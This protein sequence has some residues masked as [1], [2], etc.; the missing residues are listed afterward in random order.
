MAESE[1]NLGNKASSSAF[2]RARVTRDSSSTAVIDERAEVAGKSDR[3]RRAGAVEGASIGGE[4]S[5]TEVIILDEA[6]AARETRGVVGN[7][8]NPRVIELSDKISKMELRREFKVDVASQERPGGE[9]A[10]HSR[11][12]ATGDEDGSAEILSRLPPGTILIKQGGAASAPTGSR[13]R[14]DSDYVHDSSKDSTNSSGSSSAASYT[15]A[16]KGRR[17]QHRTGRSKK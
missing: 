7:A 8:H 11:G 15:A 13:R 6:P 9:S 4:Q 5:R 10:N 2:S 3:R 14:D 1:D 16:G 12:N 17:M